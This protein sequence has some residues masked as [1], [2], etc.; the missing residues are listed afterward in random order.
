MGYTMASDEVIADGCEMLLRDSK[1]LEK[2]ATENASLF[3][4]VVT[5]VREF[6]ANLR[7]AQ[8]DMYDG[9]EELHDAALK[10]REALKSLEEVQE[11]FDNA[12]ENSIRNMRD[13]LAEAE[14][15]KTRENL[16]VLEKQ[17]EKEGLQ[18]SEETNFDNSS[19]QKK[20]YDIIKSGMED[21][22]GESFDQRFRDIQKAC[23][24]MSQGELQSYREK[25]AELN[26]RV[27]AGLRDV[28]QRRVRAGSAGNRNGNALRLISKSG[29]QFNIVEVDA[30]TFHD[31]FE[32][33]RC[34]LENGE[35]VDLHDIKSTADTIGYED[36]TNYIADDGMSGFA[37]TKDGDLV[38]VYNL[39]T[40]RGFLSAIAPVVKERAR[41]LDCYMSPNQPLHKFYERN[42]GFKI[43]SIMDHN[44]IHDHDNIAKNHHNPQIAF[45]VNS[46][47]D[48]QT[49]HFSK[50]DYDGAKNY[51]LEQ[52]SEVQNSEEIIERDNEYLKLAKDP[53]KNA[54]QLR[55]LVDAAAKAAGFAKRLYHGTKGFGST[56]VD[57]GY[58]DDGISFFM[59]DDERVTSWY[60]GT[61]EKKPIGKNISEN[62]ANNYEFYANTD[63]MYEIDDYGAQ[64]DN[65][66][67]A[68]ALDSEDAINKAFPE[69][70]G[71]TWDEN[72]GFLNVY[73]DDVFYGEYVW[74]DESDRYVPNLPGRDP[75][76]S[77]ADGFG[78][79]TTRSLSRAIY[80]SGKYSG[81]I[82]RKIHDAGFDNGNSYADIYNFFHPE[83][84][85]KS[86]D[87]V[88]YDDN[89][90]IIP[91][92]ERF[93]TE[94]NDLRFS[95][96]TETSRDTLVS[97][98]EAVAETDE[99][100]S[101]VEKLKSEVKKANALQKE[102]AEV[103][104]KIKEISFTKGADRSAL[105]SLNEEKE[106]LA[107]KLNRLDSKFYGYRGY[108]TFKTLAER[109]SKEAVIAERLRGKE[110]LRSQKQK[111]QEAAQGIKDTLAQREENRRRRE[112]PTSP[113]NSGKNGGAVGNSPTAPP[114]FIYPFPLFLPCG[115]SR[116]SEAL[117]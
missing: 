8:T 33:C 79:G 77:R 9:N 16:D 90:D 80:D 69:S 68:D 49:R 37:I 107:K 91:L 41:T 75:L 18:F 87:L 5:K 28:F 102:L 17:A 24:E 48:V 66:L 34:F 104:R 6:I 38:S 29:E 47:S 19:T 27:R 60:S 21:E 82:F 109:K 111:Y 55:K 7:K 62:G 1:A 110:A 61:D 100:K 44:M 67:D 81:V 13:A 94:E 116:G 70:E 52:A 43:A 114:F 65:I 32:I 71:F 99:E 88:T 64:W 101:F 30:T 45:M 86:A 72:D 25:G 58:S 74:D 93:N 85:V 42:F 108:D 105:P 59:S 36:M 51:Q 76:P 92:S 2:L 4:K 112:K 96:E 78:A 113:V 26:E 14:N 53:K 3:V 11:V 50:D 115:G 73:R 15:A 95:E 23:R 40:K 106:R 22:D 46:D 97:D 10:L 84:Q 54:A 39:G 31:V 57:T 98:M 35:L 20:I 12:L 83:S 56:Q 117:R 89:G 103:N 63:N